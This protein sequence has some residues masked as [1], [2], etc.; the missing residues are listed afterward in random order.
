MQPMKTRVYRLISL[1][2]I[3][4]VLI[5][6]AAYAVMILRTSSSVYKLILL[7][8]TIVTPDDIIQDGWIL[9]QDGQ[10]SL[11]SALKPD[12]PDAIEVHTGG[13]IF[14]G[15]I[16]LHNHISYNVFPHWHPSHLFSDRYEWRNDRDYIEQVSDPYGY[17]LDHGY[18]CDMNTYGELRALAGGTTSILAT[19]PA[20]CIQGLVRNLDFNSGFYNFLEPDSRHVLDEIEMRST[21]DTVTISRVKSFLADRRSEMFIVHLSEGVDTTS[22]DEFYFLQKQGLLT[23]KTVIIHGIAL[24]STEFLAMQSAGASL[25]WS[26]RSNIELYGKTADIA[27]ALDAGLPVALA[28]DWAITGSSNILE[29]LNYAS[30]W[31]VEHLSGRLTDKQL[32]MMVTT[33]PARIAGID[34]EVGTIQE[35]LY[36]DL[37]VISGN[38]NDP[39]QALIQA[40]AGDVQL[41]LIGG[42]PI[43]GTPNFMEFFWHRSELNEISV[44][45]TLKMVQMPNSSMNISELESKLQAILASQGT[46]LAPIH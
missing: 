21:T 25:V 20:S 10:I 44:D 43:Y 17:L 45:G 31:N 11:V 9:I 34:D 5:A 33:I 2:T 6:A 23:R 27:A 38:R 28:P 37:I 29:E 41:I 46:D 35:G 13:I 24:G 15:L 22:L 14:P 36:A 32:V 4:A 19:A 7:E 39:Y 3:L 1:V 40:Q 18:F 12:V 30:Q 26:P 8:G 42:Q 16:D